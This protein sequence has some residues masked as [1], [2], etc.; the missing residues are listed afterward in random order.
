MVRDAPGLGERTMQ[1]QESPVLSVRTVFTKQMFQACWIKASVTLS[2]HESCVQPAGQASAEDC[3][4]KVAAI[5]SWPNTGGDP[6]VAGSS[7]GPALTTA[8]LRGLFRQGA[9]GG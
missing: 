6:K 9:G 2:Q 5:W 4:G 7:Q 3:R 8:L 1:E